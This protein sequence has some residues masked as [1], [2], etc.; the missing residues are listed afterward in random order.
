[1]AVKISLELGD[2]P[3]ELVEASTILI[4]ASH[5]F[6]NNAKKILSDRWF[7]KQRKYA[8]KHNLGSF[9]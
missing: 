6:D 9:L 8:K 1:M 5:C 2:V 4:R 3:I 7:R